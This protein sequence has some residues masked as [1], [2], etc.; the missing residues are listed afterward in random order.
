MLRHRQSTAFADTLAKLFETLLPNTDLKATPRLAYAGTSPGKCPDAPVTR[1]D[2][3]RRSRSR[4][5]T[6]SGSS[7]TI[8]TGWY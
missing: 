3:V 4:R 5:T 6:F 7:G 8:K 2:F 1:S